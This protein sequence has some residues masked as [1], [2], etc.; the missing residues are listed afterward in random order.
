MDLTFPSLKEIASACQGIKPEQSGI[1]VK[2]GIRGLNIINSSYSTNPNG[3]ISHLD[4]LK[5]WS[6]RKIIVMPCLIELGKASKEVHKK[7][8]ERIGEV[9]DLAIIT[10]KDRFKEIKEGAETKALF[11][12]NPIEIV[13]KIKEFSKKGDVVLLEGRVPKQVTQQV[14]L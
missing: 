14:V 5:T 12:E 3:V 7:I 8:G 9:C 13:E 11:L 6:G 2:K 1:E 10:T 4:Y